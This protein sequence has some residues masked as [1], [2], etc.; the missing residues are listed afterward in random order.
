M[1][2]GAGEA[3]VEVEPGAGLPRDGGEAGRG[4][5]EGARRRVGRR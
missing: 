1:R 2:P 4:T 3:H 5:G